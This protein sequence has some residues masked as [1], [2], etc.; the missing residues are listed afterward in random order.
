MKL[1]IIPICLILFFFPLLGSN[2]ADLQKIQLTPQEQE[3]IKTHPL[4]QFGTDETFHPYVI[5]KADGRIEGL[6]VDFLEYINRVTG[7]NIKL[8][9]GQWRDIV[10]QAKERGI[11]GLTTSIITPKRAEF[12]HFSTSYVREFPLLVV[13]KEKQ[14]TLDSLHDLKG[15]T[16]AAQKGLAIFELMLKKN[17][18]INSVEASSEVECIKL[19]LE[20]KADAALIASSTY[21]EHLE[22]F[23]HGIKIG[24]VLEEAGLDM[25][26]SIRKDW[27]ELKSIINKALSTLDRHDKSLL[28]ERWFGKDII[29]PSSSKIQLTVDER[30]FVSQHP[31]L[32]VGFNTNLPPFEFINQKNQ[33]LGI[34]TE[35]LK[36]LSDMLG[37]EFKLKFYPSNKKLL[38]DIIA[39]K[40][41]LIVAFDAG[42]TNKNILPRTKSYINFPI[43]IV[44]NNQVT[45]IDSLLY[46]NNKTVAVLENSTS[47]HLLESN[48]PKIKL[49]LETDLV[50]ALNKVS[51]GQTYAFVGNLA[52]VSHTI[53]KE[54]LTNLKVS[55]EI[56][57]RSHLSM[58]VRPDW[59]FLVTLLDKAIENV[60]PKQ[61][62]EMLSHWITLVYEKKV[63]THVIWMTILISVLILSGILI[64]NRKRV[65]AE[66][67]K[68]KFFKLQQ[69]YQKQKAENYFEVA[70]V[71]FLVLDECQKIKAINQKGSEILGYPQAELIG[72]KWTDHFI[73]H[74]F[75]AK[76]KEVFEEAKVRPLNNYESYENPILDARGDEK[77]IRWNNRTLL[78]AKGNF[79]GILCAGEDIS[80]RVKLEKQL[81]HS[82]KLEALG[83]LSGGIAH[84]FNNFLT[85]IL[86]SAQFG[87]KKL[88]QQEDVTPFLE[89][90]IRTSKNAINI[91][92]QILY[93]TKVGQGVL[94]EVDPLK[95]LAE[96]HTILRTTIPSHIEISV[97]NDS[98]P[99]T[100]L[101][102]KSQLQQ[103]VINLANNAS[104]AM[105]KDGGKIEITTSIKTLNQIPVSLPH[106]TNKTPS[107]C[108]IISIKDNGP[109]IPHENLSRIFDPFFTTKEVGEGTGLGLSVVHGIMDRHQGIITVD[110]NLGQGAEF[111]LYF[112]CHTKTQRENASAPIPEPSFRHGSGHILLVDD[113]PTFTAIY[114]DFLSSLGYQITECHDG[115]EALEIFRKSPDQI[116]LVIADMIMPLL[117]GK[118]LSIEMLNIRPDLPILII[119]GHFDVI[120]AEESNEIGVHQLLRKPIDLVELSQILADILS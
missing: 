65:Q 111:K 26:F 49:Q 61:R 29:K 66:Q 59:P 113:E 81:R 116:D 67:L 33:S 47:H 37:F 101:A 57:I 7:L 9:V 99:V 70:S 84:E 72:K 18:Q 86:G 22:A 3:F 58:V 89:Q 69:E 115:K 32:R 96:S 19:M 94:K 118:D 5:K 36:A 119:T 50:P 63:S 54:G 117:S 12:F 42:L 43:V 62:D 2:T 8:K 51:Q 41:D 106:Q 90:I 112:Y 31:I 71:L 110:S 85:I 82:Q 60:P 1:F 120:S 102:D 14:K 39:K 11:D 13:P 98:P 46:L 108:F 105:G 15:K 87:L 79:K 25:V 52:T 91:V 109:G 45:Y 103:I 88:K 20:G 78:D 23:T 38:S 10:V 92:N 107:D 40:L 97:N 95:T 35:Y 68:S 4:I 21:R 73:P 104:Q 17:P 74:R 56:K 77:I 55:G 93:F 30:E 24:L 48:F 53:R 114:K 6:D 80:N 28:Y 76:I 27:P 34:S 83:T 64:W 16:I 75:R 44:T 100:I